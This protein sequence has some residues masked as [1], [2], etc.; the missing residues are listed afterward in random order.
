MTVLG[1]LRLSHEEIK[2]IIADHISAR[3]GGS[4]EVELHPTHDP[5]G[6]EV[7]ANVSISNGLFQGPV[8]QMDEARPVQGLSRHAGG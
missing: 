1:T 8:S 3:Y 4:A 2:Q 6:N 7:R 5:Y